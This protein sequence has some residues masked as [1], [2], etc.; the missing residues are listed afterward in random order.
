MLNK[1]DSSVAQYKSKVKLSFLEKH[2]WRNT[3]LGNFIL[4]TKHTEYEKGNKARM[5]E[6]IFSKGY[7]RSIPAWNQDLALGEPRLGVRTF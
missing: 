5:T 3:Y 4:E 6:V 2:G 7:G 1:N